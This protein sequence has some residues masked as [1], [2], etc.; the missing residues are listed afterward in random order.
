MIQIV[1]YSDQDI[2]QMIQSANSKERG[3][4]L[5]ME[6]HQRP[7]YGYLRRNLTSHEDTD[8]V[9]QLS[10]IK[11]F[12]SLDQFEGRCSLKTWLYKIASNE[13]VSYLRSKTF[14]AYQTAELTSAHE[15]STTDHGQLQEE[16]IQKK[17]DAA[18]QS[19]PEK[20]KMVFSLRYFEEMPYS[21]MSQILETS[22]G[23][24]KASYHHAVK[25]IQ[26]SLL[27]QES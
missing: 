22:E 9:I 1:V 17:F 4:R 23:A 26:Q 8:D 3:Y 6:A 14:K 7:L 16:D 27:Q 21:E 15:T 20:Q 19:L 2:L 24:L 13:C 10:F 12:R 18:L 25:K 11:F 5:L